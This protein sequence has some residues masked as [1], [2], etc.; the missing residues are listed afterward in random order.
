MK[1]FVLM[2]CVLGM[3]SVA[4][5]GSISGIKP[6]ELP[7]SPSAQEL[8]EFRKYQLLYAELERQSLVLQ[9]FKDYQTLSPADV[10]NQSHVLQAGFRYDSE[11][12]KA[13]AQGLEEFRD[14]NGE[15]RANAV[16]Q[17]QHLVDALVLRYCDVYAQK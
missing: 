9:K 8:K 1:R 17:K 5:A 4:Y 3:V 14:L 6:P 13:L 11:T 15:E 10:D 2:V 12:M 7:K 16:Q